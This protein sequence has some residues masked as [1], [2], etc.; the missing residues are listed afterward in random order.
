MNAP[1]SKRCAVAGFVTLRRAGGDPVTRVAPEAGFTLGFPEYNFRRHLGCSPS[2]YRNA[3][4]VRIRRGAIVVRIDP[5][6]RA[7]RPDRAP[8]FGRGAGS[9]GVVPPGMGKAVNQWR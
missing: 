9:G 5:E 8:P 4:R 6:A 1:S 7:G 3:H 2:D